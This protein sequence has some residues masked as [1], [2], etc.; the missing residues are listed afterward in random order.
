MPFFAAFSG[1]KTFWHIDCLTEVS[2]WLNYVDFNLALSGLIGGD[3]SLLGVQG[4]R[5]IGDKH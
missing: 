4:C 3:Q 2:G 1:L 5:D